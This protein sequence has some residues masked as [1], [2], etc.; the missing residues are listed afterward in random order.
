MRRGVS[1]QSLPA[2]EIHGVK[3][4]GRGSAACLKAEANAPS[5]IGRVMAVSAKPP[6]GA[7]NT[8]AGAGHSDAGGV[9]ADSA[10]VEAEASFRTLSGEEV[11]ELYTA[12]DL[13]A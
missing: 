7:D 8:D 12:E 1:R 2:T 10:A 5:S 4:P 11:R 13:P 6:S 3:R 9:P